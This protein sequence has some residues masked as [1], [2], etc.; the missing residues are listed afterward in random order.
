MPQQQQHPSGSF[1][2]SPDAFTASL[3][4]KTEQEVFHLQETARAAKLA[5]AAAAAKAAGAAGD[6]GAAAAAADAAAVEQLGEEEDD[7][8]DVINPETG[9]VS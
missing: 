4:S 6:A 9:E 1:N 2:T 7:T 8:I 5:E 3:Q